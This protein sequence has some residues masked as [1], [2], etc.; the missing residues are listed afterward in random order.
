M[1]GGRQGRRVVTRAAFLAAYREALA[2]YPWAADAARLARFLASCDAT[3]STDRATWN[4][5]GD[6]V[7]AAWR[8]IGGKGRPTLKA[9]RA[10][11]ACVKVP[12]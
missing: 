2:V 10:L 6:A 12:S 3:L 11:P 4:H 9:L 5:D 1:P 8:A 7:V